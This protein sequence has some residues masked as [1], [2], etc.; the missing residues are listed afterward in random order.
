MADCSSRVEPFWTDRNTVL[1]TM[2]TEHTERV[3]QIGETFLSGQIATIRQE[4]VSL[5]QASRTDEFVRVP[6]ERGATG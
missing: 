6:P 4:T 2:A 1:D 5:Q 3:I